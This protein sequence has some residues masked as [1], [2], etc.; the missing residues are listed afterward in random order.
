MQ[1]NY[2]RTKSPLF[3][4]QLITYL[5][6]ITVPNHLKDM[7]FLKLH[8]SIPAI[9]VALFLASCGFI[10]GIFQ[11][12]M[13]VGLFMVLGLSGGLIVLIARMGYK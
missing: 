9:L 5:A 13:G 10:S 6:F 11:A 1:M 7:K 2:L 8:Q 3:N 12:G 4:Q